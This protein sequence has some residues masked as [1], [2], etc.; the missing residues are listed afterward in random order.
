MEEIVRVGRWVLS[1]VL[2]LALGGLLL[3]LGFGVGG[4]VG[5]GVGLV[6]IALHFYFSRFGVGWLGVHPKELFNYNR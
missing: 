2:E 4:L 6:G 5:F 3:V 1:V